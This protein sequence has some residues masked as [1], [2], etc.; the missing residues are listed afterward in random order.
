MGLDLP[1]VSLVPRGEVG[2]SIRVA[3]HGPQ[4]PV[5]NSLAKSSTVGIT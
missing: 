2:C 4:H 1:L 3:L 5:E